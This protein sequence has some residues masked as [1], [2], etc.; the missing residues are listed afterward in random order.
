MSCIQ[1][2]A[3]R[4]PSV[5]FICTVSQLLYG[6][7]H[8]TRQLRGIVSWIAHPQKIWSLSPVWN[9]CTWPYWKPLCRFH[10]VRWGYT[11]LGEALHLEPLVGHVKT[12]ASSWIRLCSRKGRDW[13]VAAA[14]QGMPKNVNNHQNLGV[15]SRTFRRSQLMI[16]WIWST[17][18]SSVRI[19]SLCNDMHVLGILISLELIHVISLRHLP[20]IWQICGFQSPSIKSSKQ[21]HFYLRWVLCLQGLALSHYQHQAFW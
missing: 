16:V 18:L 19:K 21:G 20:M 7:Q 2:I 17:G 1:T 11:G 3:R 9:L 14:K 12:K 10:R 6:R 5:A 13:P 4:I 8:V 15:S